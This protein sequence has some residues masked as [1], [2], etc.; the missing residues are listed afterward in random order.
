MHAG[1]GTQ[2]AVRGLT[3]MN[4]YVPAPTWPPTPEQEASQQ[5]TVLAKDE[6][7]DTALVEVRWPGRLEV[8]FASVVLSKLPELVSTRPINKY[9]VVRPVERGVP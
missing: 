6:E 3:N 2:G 9:C 1:T 7:G 8:A 5:V 4:T